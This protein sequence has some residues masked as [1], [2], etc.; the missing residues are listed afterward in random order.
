MFK[1]PY[2]LFQQQVADLTKKNKAEDKKKVVK[3]DVD[4]AMPIYT[5]EEL[6][7]ME[8]EESSSTTKYDDDNDEFEEY[9]SDD[10]YEDKN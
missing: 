9:D 5:E 10:Y 4:N 8:E 1:K 7:K 6:K 2:S 3:I